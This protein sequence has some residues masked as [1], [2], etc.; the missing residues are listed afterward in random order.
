MR[1]FE[2]SSQLDMTPN[3]DDDTIEK[4]IKYCCMDIKPM[5]SLE[6]ERFKQF[7]QFLLDVGAKYGK[8]DIGDILPHPTTVSRHIEKQIKEII[9][10]KIYFLSLKKNIVHRLVICQ[11]CGPITFVSYMSITLHYIDDNWK[12]NNRL[13]H[14][15]KFKMNESKTGENIKRF[16]YNFFFQIVYAANKPRNDLMSSITFV[17]NQGT[18]MLSTLRNINRLICR[19]YLLNTALRKLF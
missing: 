7:W 10:L 8:I 16:L 19:A 15:G 6:G 3:D 9:F 1:S 17:T 18:N 14:T 5:Y 4:C 12:L 2:T 13:L 11:I